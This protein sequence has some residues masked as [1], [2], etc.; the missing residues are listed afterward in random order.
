MIDLQ[1]DHPHVPLATVATVC[2][3]FGHMLRSISNKS[4]TGPLFDCRF[5]TVTV[6]PGGLRAPNARTLM[7]IVFLLLLLARNKT[8]IFT[9]DPMPMLLMFRVSL[10]YVSVYIFCKSS[11]HPSVPVLPQ[12]TFA[13]AL[14]V[15]HEWIR[16]N[17]SFKE[18]VT[19][20]HRA[21]SIF[22]AWR[23]SLVYVR[24]CV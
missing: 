4:S 3:R 16:R 13:G 7:T 17:G 15:L 20:T 8:T 19:I 5:F 21:G 1:T 2:G 9:F 11:G 14:N 22:S 24:V 6:L 23:L 12:Q 10:F 18:I